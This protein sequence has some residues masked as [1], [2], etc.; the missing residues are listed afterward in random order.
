MNK[1]HNKSIKIVLFTIFMF[2]LIGCQNE[3]LT[4]FQEEITFDLTNLEHVEEA[5]GTLASALPDILAADQE[6]SNVIYAEAKSNVD[7]E[8]FALWSKIIENP[9]SVGLKSK[10]HKSLAKTKYNVS[11]KVLEEIPELQLYVHNFEKWDQKNQIPVTFTPLTINDVDVQELTVYEQ[12]GN[13]YTL[14]VSDKYW[15]P[16]FPIMVV[17]L[18]EDM[19]LKESDNTSKSIGK[20]NTSAP[21]IIFA[22]RI[23]VGAPRD[24]EPWW[25][26]KLEMIIDSGPN[27]P[28][29]VPNK[30][31]G[32][33]TY[34]R[35]DYHY[36][37]LYEGWDYE[38]GVGIF[39]YEWDSGHDELV[40]FA[41]VYFPYSHS[42]AEIDHIVKFKYFYCDG[43]P[44]RCSYLFTL[45]TL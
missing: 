8:A 11:E 3:N 5:L 34:G 13:S 26:G 15:E 29:Y 43:D 27:W 38:Q 42:S 21:P 30:S 2:L 18:N 44:Y 23:W 4:N 39:V 36:W 9:K 32:C 41:R 1:Q 25:K 28:L 19:M 35:S 14:D 37:P 24:L 45:L 10:L 16:D 40:E 7:V 22:N 12:N 6:I 33:N 17:G 20:A 31:G